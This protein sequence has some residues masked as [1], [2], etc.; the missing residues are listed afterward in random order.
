[1]LPASPSLTELHLGD[2][3]LG[4]EGVRQLSEGLRDPACR[5]QSLR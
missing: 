2:N 1:M 5:L 3:E 4:D